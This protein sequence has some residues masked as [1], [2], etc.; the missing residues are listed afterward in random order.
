[1]LNLRCSAEGSPL[2]AQSSTKAFRECTIDQPLRGTVVPKGEDLN[3]LILPVLLE[4]G[5]VIP[6][7]SWRGVPE[8][9][10][11]GRKDDHRKITSRNAVA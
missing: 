10:E 4:D 11:A 1:M 9:G 6:E 2:S 7:S 3:E 5:D 8:R